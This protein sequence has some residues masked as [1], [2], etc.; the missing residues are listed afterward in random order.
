MNI[1]KL[2]TTSD[3]MKRAGVG[4]ETLRFYEEQ[5]LI[6]P[7]SRTASG[8]RQFT[9]TV[10]EV[11][12]FIKDTQQ[13]GFS[14][15]E[16]KVLLKLRASTMNTCDNVGALLDTKRR[17]IDDEIAAWQRKRTVIDAMIGNC[18]AVNNCK[19]AVSV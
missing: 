9:P 15:K 16:I 3:V 6:E 18:C 14:L 17:A 8:Y 10:V 13:A 19:P 2:L 7:I 12:T 1:V 5:G 4:R 11:I